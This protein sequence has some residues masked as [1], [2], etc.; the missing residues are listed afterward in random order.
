MIGITCCLFASELKEKKH[1]PVDLKFSDFFVNPIGPRGLEF[2]DTLRNLDGKRVRIEGYMVQQD[3][4]LPDAFLL[5]PLPLRLHEDEYG[6]ADDLPATTLH[7]FSQTKE[8]QTY[9]SGILIVTG[10]LRIGNR[11]EPDG[12]IS[13]VRLILDA[14]TTQKKCEQQSKGEETNVEN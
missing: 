1:P 4:P 8:N 13:T 11:E 10:T 7:V 14:P 3:Q 2:T 12:R 5:T 9:R 6:M